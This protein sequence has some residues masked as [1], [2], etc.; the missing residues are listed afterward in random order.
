MLSFLIICPVI[1]KKV[2]KVD[3]HFLEQDEL[4]RLK[5]N[6]SSPEASTNFSTGWNARRSLNLLRMS[7]GQRAVDSTPGDNMDI[8]DDDVD[9]PKLA[10]CVDTDVTN[11]ISHHTE[12]KEESSD[13]KHIDEKI[14]V[15]EESN[16]TEFKVQAG[17]QSLEIQTSCVDTNVTNLISQHTEAKEESSDDKHIDEKIQVLEES[18]TTEFK[19]QAGDQSLEDPT[20]SDFDAECDLSIGRCDKLPK[21]LSAEKLFGNGMQISKDSSLTSSKLKSKG[22]RAHHASSDRLAMSLQHGLQVISNRHQKL[23][24]GRTSLSFPFKVVDFMP[25]IPIPKID[26]GVQTDI[27]EENC[28][29]SSTFIC[30]V[31]REGFLR[32]SRQTKNRSDQEVQS[33]ALDIIEKNADGNE[34]QLVLTDATDEEKGARIADESRS[35]NLLPKVY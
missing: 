27:S 2:Q 1:Q 8:D 34:L 22:K 5:A 9:I 30:S 26:V 4:L 10:S 14:Q 25:V 33:V 24:L 29:D 21:S 11:L 23:T 20:I 31:C 18:N 12:A 16:T 35:T 7:L 17:D 28:E 6:G 13:D 15:P 19:V 3:F 32:R